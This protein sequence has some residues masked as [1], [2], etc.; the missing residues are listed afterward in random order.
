[1]KGARI[2]VRCDCGEINHLEYGETWDCAKCGRRWNTAQ[3]PSEEYWGIMREMR[4]FRFRAIRVAIVGGAVFAL[5]ALTE[6]TSFLL[7]L[8]IFMSGWYLYYMPQWRKRVRIRARSLPEW[9]LHP[10]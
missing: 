1:V 8:P 2:T 5:L 7:L 4:Q 6:S 9:E 10:E 3:I